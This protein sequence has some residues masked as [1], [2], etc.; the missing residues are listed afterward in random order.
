[1]TNALLW[2]RM[3]IAREA[4][5]VE[6]GGVLELSVLAVPFCCKPKSALK[7]KAFIKKKMH[8][9]VLWMGLGL[10]TQAHQPKRQPTYVHQF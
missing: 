10:W 1:M 5:H 8:Q 9:P 3:P 6:V 7:Y 2:C 4:V